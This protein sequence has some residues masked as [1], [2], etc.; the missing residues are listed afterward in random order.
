[1]LKYF[2]NPKSVAI[3]GASHTPGKIGYTI[4][5]NFVKGN[6]KGKIYPINP[7]TT[8]IFDLDVYP[9]VKDI[10]DKIELAIIVVPALIVPKVLRECVDKK[11]KAVVIVSGGF[12]ES[13]EEG[14]KLEEKLKKIIKNS[15]TRVLGPNCLGVLDI[16]TGVDTLFLQRERL[17]RPPA[18]G[19]GYISQSGSV[20]S[21]I[22][23]WLAE[24]NVGISKFISYENGMDLNECDCI[25]FL[26]NDKKTKV[27]VLFIEGVK[28]G[29][30]FIRIVKKVS[31][32]KPV[33]VLKGGKTEKGIKAV[34]S[35]TGAL[36]GSAKIYSSVFKQSGAIEANSW[37]ELFD[38][39]RAF[40]QPL[41]KGNRVVIVTDGGGFGILATDECE[42]EEL[43]LPEPSKKLKKILRKNLPVY[44]SVTNPID[45]SGDAT[46]ERYKVVIEGCLKSGEYD[47]VIAIVLFQIPTL[48][49]KVVGEIVGLKK[50]GKPILCCSAGG[51]FTIKLSRNF[52][53]EGIPVYPTPER[54][55][56]AFAALY[57]YR[58]FLEKK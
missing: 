25:E 58:K 11:I 37:E 5:E 49:P 21:T 31:K 38:F 42:R 41:P 36:A 17:T 51:A 33:I 8:P 24:E 10:K 48:E 13:G 57:R 23:D 55:V 26:A 6:Y 20:G 32:K 52:E 50:Y 43:K 4:L 15:K 19:I 7:N 30:R 40:S 22:L 16:T 56:R 44:A 14:K 34:A 47:G 2:F 45:I 39:A 53:K 46:A 29:K 9:S 54:A 27:I 3:I 18:G 35:H 12:S 28:D 1:M